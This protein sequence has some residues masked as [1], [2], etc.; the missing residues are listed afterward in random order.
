M[1]LNQY[2]EKMDTTTKLSLIQIIHPK[3]TLCV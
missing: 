2:H 1:D 3:T